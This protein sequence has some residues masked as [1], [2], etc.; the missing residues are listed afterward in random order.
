MRKD[1][2]KTSRRNGDVDLHIHTSA[3]D[4]SLTPRQNVLLAIKKSIKVIGIADHDSISGI[5]EALDTAHS[6]NSKII[7]V[8]AVEISCGYCSEELH[9]VGY[10]VDH[11]NPHIKRFLLNRQKN[12]FKRARKLLS[13][14]NKQLILEGKSPIQFHEVK[15]RAKGSIGKP[16][17]AAEL[18]CTG[19]IKDMNEA[20]SKYLN[21]NAAGYKRISVSKAIN[22]IKKSGGIPAI[23]HPHI[24][25]RNIR[26]NAKEQFQILKQLQKKGIECVEVFTTAH[27]RKQEKIYLGF[28]KRLGMLVTGGSDSHGP[29]TSC[30][31]LG[32]FGVKMKY[33]D[34]LLKRKM[35]IDSKKCID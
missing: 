6:Y 31:Y 20:F 7:V 12:R 5:Q 21:Y 13:A 10:F 18:M 25:F 4:G 22:I 14:V 29:G 24:S 1:L 34:L 26:P 32:K 35:E 16:H 30:D 3:S 28:A 11:N 15:K 17:I 9:I 19:H 33:Y 23:A 8:P 2:R 27:T